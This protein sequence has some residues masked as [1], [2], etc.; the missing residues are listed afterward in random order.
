LLLLIAGPA[1]AQLQSDR[2]TMLSPE[3]MRAIATEL[4]GARAY[5]NVLDIAAY[6]HIR[7]AEEYTSTYRE[8][9]VVERLA[10]DYGFSNV[11]ITR[12]PVPY[13]QWGGQDAEL[14]ITEPE[15]R[16]VS[17]YLD[18]PAMLAV[19][20]QSADVTAPLIWVGLGTKDTDYTGKDVRGKRVLT[21]AT[22][23][24]P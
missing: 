4:S 24:P 7:P 12:L 16:L 5:N 21:N 11:R 6:E 3:T 20:S 18:H 17:R 1:N 9:T 10:K 22:A 23:A 15:R 2:P 13:R 8:S 19:G 14:W